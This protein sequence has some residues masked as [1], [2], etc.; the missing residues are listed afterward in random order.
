MAKAITNAILSLLV[1]NKPKVYFTEGHDEYDL[2]DSLI[3]MI[4]YRIL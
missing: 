2:S 4:D 1:E 3:D